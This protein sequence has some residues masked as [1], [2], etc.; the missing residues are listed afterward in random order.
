MQ[1]VS[2]YSNAEELET[3]LRH[4]FP[5]IYEAE[6]RAAIIA[7]AHVVELKAGDIWIDIGGY[8]KHIPL[9]L[10]G[11]LKLLREDGSGNEILLYFVGPGETCAMSLTCCMSDARSTIR[12]IAEEDTVLLAVPVRFMDEWTERFR[13][14]KSFVML[15]YQRRFEELLRTIDGVAFQKL[16]VR[17]LS[18]LR[19][20]VAN[21]GSAVV[22]IT[23]Q[24]L[25]NELNSS[26]EVISRLLKGMENDRLLKLG[27]Q[28]IEVLAP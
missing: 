10:G 22:Q 23:H 25:A 24:E 27:R 19:E 11:M 18:L 16:D 28:R 1:A 7:S 6:A 3:T 20:R 13:S 4:V 26:R 9:V 21:Q 15:T 14:W 8:I 17:I 5:D 12:V 2:V